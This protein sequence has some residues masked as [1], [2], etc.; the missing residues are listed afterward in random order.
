M[1]NHL[2]LA[3]DLGAQRAEQE[4][5]QKT[6]DGWETAGNYMTPAFGAIGQPWLAGLTS[7]ATTPQGGNATQAGV[8]TGLA[9]AG[10]GLAGG[11]GGAAVGGAL[12]YGGGHLANALG[13]DVDPEEIAK[14]TALLG[15]G[16][17]AGFGGGY[18]AYV[19]HNSVNKGQ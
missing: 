19:G 8:R 9:S 4:F 10:G 5:M 15:G 11:L 17:G 6:A 18:G 1:N 14:Y 2:K 13:A 3:Y 12:G 7:A 16:I